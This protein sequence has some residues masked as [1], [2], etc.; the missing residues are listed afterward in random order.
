[1]A[2]TWRRLAAEH[3]SYEMLSNVLSEL[4]FGEPYEALPRALKMHSWAA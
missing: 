3:E 4:E 1:M 2:E